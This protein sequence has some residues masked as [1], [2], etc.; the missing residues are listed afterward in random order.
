MRKSTKTF[1]W[2]FGTIFLIGG[3]ASLFIF[4]GIQQTALDFLDGYLESSVDP[5]S[6]SCST[7]ARDTTGC[8]SGSGACPNRQSCIKTSEKSWDTEDVKIY[9]TYSINWRSNI[10]YD[11]GSISL[12]FGSISI[13]FSP[14]HNGIGQGSGVVEII[15]SV[16]SPSQIIVTNN[17]NPLGTFTISKGNMQITASSIANSYFGGDSSSTSI[18]ISQIREKVPFGC[19]VSSSEVLV[20]DDFSEGSR[21]QLVPERTLTFAPS[22]FCFDQPAI[23]RTLGSDG[24]LQQDRLGEIFNKITS[25]DSVTVS[26]GQVIRVPYITEYK[27][28]LQLKC[29]V[30]EA[31]ST[32][33]KQCNKIVEEAK[34]PSQSVAS[35]DTNILQSLKSSFTYTQTKDDA[36]LRIGSSSYSGNQP[37]FSCIS[38][39]SEGGVGAGKPSQD[40]WSTSID[41]KTIKSGASAKLNDYL[42]ASYAIAGD[43]IKVS[44]N[45]W[46][47]DTDAVWIN[48]FSFELAD[49]AV[50]ITAQQPKTFNMQLGKDYDLPFSINNHLSS[51]DSRH[52]GVETVCIKDIYNVANPTVSYP[53]A[54]TSGS[55]S[56]DVPADTSRL[57]K[58]DCEVRPYIIIDADRETKV[59]MNSIAKYSYEVTPCEGEC[60]STTE[61]LSQETVAEPVKLSFW[62]KIVNW[63]KGWFG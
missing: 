46:S 41:G 19:S 58:V 18:T 8:P 39:V 2:I 30:G 59:L 32:L 62:Q 14:P 61:E 63:F 4:S 6:L 50:A 55:F 9:Y 26:S 48:I 53:L 47:Y 40:C 16:V 51:F 31:Y 34:N 52:S 28:G 20:F 49:N 3:L 35:V 54:F 29:N 33:T 17:G 7:S 60:P 37:S 57:G 27:E 15:H 11:H 1:I 36:P 24:G 13:P 38:E 25:G 23:V 56:Y 5:S 45:Q 42:S 43:G 21:I 10:G 12:N 22:R 44:N